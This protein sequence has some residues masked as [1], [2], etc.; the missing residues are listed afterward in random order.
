MGKRDM[1]YF[2]MAMI[3]VFGFYGLSVNPGLL[4]LTT[5]NINTLFGLLPG[6]LVALVSIISVNK[7]SG[8]GKMGS[9][10][11]V[12]I[13]LIVLIGS[14][15]TAGLVTPDMLNGL[16]IVQTKI[17]IIVGSIIVGAISA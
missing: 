5:V 10:F 11:G 16:T 14:A 1:Q 13:G 3:I 17:W 4:G 9:I 6:L 8:I 2:Y 7:T 12:G 15:D